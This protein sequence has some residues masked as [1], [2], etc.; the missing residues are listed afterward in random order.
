M[1]P[2]E[3]KRLPAIASREC[4]S[5]GAF[6]GIAI[7]PFYV[8]VLSATGLGVAFFSQDQIT[9]GVVAMVV[10]F[11]LMFRFWIRMPL[12]NRT[13]GWWFGAP[14]KPRGVTDADIQD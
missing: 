2:A 1:S 3:K 8:W 14:A 6:L 13:S 12:A 9:P 10:V 11:G 5:C 4:Q 7:I